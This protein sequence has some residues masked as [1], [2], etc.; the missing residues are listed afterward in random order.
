MLKRLL[1]SILIMAALQAYGQGNVPPSWQ[2]TTVFDREAPVVLMPDLDIEALLAEDEIRHAQK[3]GPYKFGENIPVELNLGNSG[4][5]ETEKNGNRLWRLGIRSMG[6]YT[7]NFIFSDLYLPPGSAF[8]LYNDDRTEMYGPYTTADVRD[9]RGFATFPMR[10]ELIWLEYSEPAAMQGQG[11]IAL[12]TVTHGYRDLY[13][14]ARG[15]G[16]GACN[17]NINCPEGQPWQDE[18]R[19]VA[20]MISG[21]SGFCTGAMVNNTAQDGTPYFLTANH[22]LGGSMAN[23][24]FKF[25]YESANCNGTGAPA[26]AGGQ[27]IQGATL[28]ANNA[29]SDFGL[30]QL[31]S[32][33]PAAFNVYYAGWDNSGDVAPNVIGIHH[34][35]GDIKK[36]SFENNAVDATNWG[37][38]ACWHVPNW[39][40]GTTE[41]GSSGSPLFD[42]AHH[43]I[44]QLYGGDA[45]CTNNVNDYYGR[46]SVSWNTGTT[47]ATRLRDWLDPSNT[48]TT[49][50]GWDPNAPVLALDAGLTGLTGIASGAIQCND[51][52]TISYTLRNY[53]T[54][55]LTSATV[56]WTIDGVA[57]TPYDWTGN[58]TTNQTTTVN[59]PTQTYT[60]GLHTVAFV[61]TMANGTT[62]P[63]ANNDQV[64]VSFTIVLGT[65]AQVMLTTDQ[66]GEETS[67][68]ITDANG[69]VVASGSGYGASTDYTVPA[70][71]ADGCYTFTIYDSYGDGMCCQYGNGSYELMDPFGVL[72]TSGGSFQD[73]ESFDFCLPLIVEPPVAAFSTA[74]TSVC[75]GLTVN[76]TN[77]STPANGNSYAWTFEGG[78]PATSAAANPTVTYATAGTY[79]VS[80]TV[81]NSA[82]TDTQ[83]STDFI[84]VNASPTATATSTPVDVTTGGSNGTA[85]VNVTGGT[86]PF[87]YDWNPG[88][89]NSE[90]VNG[91]NAGNYTVTVTDANGCTATA[92]T[93]VGSNVGITDAAWATAVR[94]YPNPTRG[95]LMVQ[96]PDGIKANEALLIDMTGRALARYSMNGNTRLSLDLRGMSEGLY[97]LR[98]STAT[99]AAVFKVALMD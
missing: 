75:A 84:T 17:N 11:S 2:R 83:A 8:Y 40:D 93:V 34:P 47:A 60:A 16:S 39:D 96:L 42:P 6:A 4:Q 19:A 61:V 24:T 73:S 1:P 20:I 31:N 62:D 88:T 23:W 68:D 72:I 82:G 79:N 65:E 3:V 5:W 35:S 57:Q 45:N 99:E 36:I 27:F 74:S 78:T 92:Q 97:H 30:L 58:L 7:V 54:E 86:A 56:E 15:G 46:F 41:P 13:D 21:G 98:I 63:N 12:E 69:N 28:K 91:L 55:P 80:L 95:E 18:K 64:S 70:C 94:L 90:T 25:N 43:I 29:G 76:F 14:M 10:G 48:A 53:G 71:L 44:G 22:C 32:T 77:Q 33:P 67:W 9:D 81:T 87:T 52:V 26:L 49:L 85:T 66:Y 59:L 51:Q 38:A 37:G 50:D 89:G